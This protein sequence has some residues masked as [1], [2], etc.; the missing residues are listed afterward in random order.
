M[1]ENVSFY[2][3]VLGVSMFIDF[4]VALSFDLWSDRKK[5]EFSTSG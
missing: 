1:I 4:D 5:L 2:V 3:A